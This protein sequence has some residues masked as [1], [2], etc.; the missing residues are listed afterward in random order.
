MK[1]RRHCCRCGGAVSCALSCANA[2]LIGSFRA[3]GFPGRD[4]SVALALR[5]PATSLALSRVSKALLTGPP[6]QGP[7]Y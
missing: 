7:S 6:T 4:G 2:L 1:V 3:L 5:G